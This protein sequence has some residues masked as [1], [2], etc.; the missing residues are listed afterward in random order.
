MNRFST[1]IIFL[2]MLAAGGTLLV[3]CDN[4]DLLPNKKTKRSCGEPK[5]TLR[6]DIQQL[7]VNFSIGEASGTIDQVKWSFGNGS[8]TVTTGTTATHT[9]AQPGTYNVQATLTN[10]CKTEIT[11]ITSVTV[12]NAVLPTVTLQP[13]A[14]ISKTTAK[15]TMAITSNGNATITAYGICYSSSNKVPALNQSDCKT[16][17]ITGTGDINKDFP[18]SVTG[19]SPNT[20]YYIRSYAV[21]QAGPGYSSPVLTFTTGQDPSVTTLG[22]SNVASTTATVGLVVNTPGTPSAVEYGICYS[23]NSTP[24]L[25]NGSKHIV[26]SPPVGTNVSVPLTDL[27]PN[28]TYYYRAY[29]KLPSGEIIYSTTIL[30]FTTPLDTVTNDLIA[31]VSFTDGS[32]KDITVYKNDANP[33]GTPTFTTDRRDRPNSAILLDGVEDYFFMN[34]NASLNNLD[35]F[36]ISLWIKA[37]P[38]NNVND[39]IQIFNKSKWATSENE[40]YSALIKKSESGSNN[41]IFMADIKQNSNCQPGKGW[42]PSTFSGKLTPGAWTHLVYVY[43]KNTLS[44]YYNNSPLAQSDPLPASSM[45]KCP[46]GELKFGAQLREYPNYFS[47][48]MD[49]IRIYKRA[50]RPDEVKSLFEQ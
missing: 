14:D 30:S 29:A 47:G 2:L 10:A 4:W 23:L 36:S 7:K 18:T 16:A 48:A 26:T 37:N 31:S 33:A 43:S 25:N 41:Y 5:G 50:L 9:Y 27:T 40:M 28:K 12:S 46:G 15:A 8:T 19:L 1:Y 38:I 6:A 39:R 11:L 13:I 22:S 49:D 17:P 32:M 21:N 44:I 20:T 42:Q 34:D 24:D 35:E 45:D 3:S